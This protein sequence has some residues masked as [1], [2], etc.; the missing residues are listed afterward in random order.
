MSSKKRD[1]RRSPSR[2]RLIEDRYYDGR[3]APKI[4]YDRKKERKRNICRQ[5]LTEE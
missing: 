5:P 3:F 1:V 4:F 2:D